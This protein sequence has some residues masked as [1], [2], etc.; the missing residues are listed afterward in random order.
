MEVNFENC[1]LSVSQNCENI[2]TCEDIA[3]SSNLQCEI[4]ENEND[5]FKYSV[6]WKGSDAIDH[7]ANKMQKLEMLQPLVPVGLMAKVKLL[8]STAV[9]PK[10]ANTSDSGWDLVITKIH[11]KIGNVTF[12]STEVS[13]EPPHGYYFDLVPRSSLSKTGYIMANSVGIID[14]SYRGPIIAA[15]MKVD[16]NAEELKLPC[17][18]VQLILRPWYNCLM[19]Q[20]ELTHTQRNDGGFGSTS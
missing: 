4:H 19:K 9:M 11:K 6:V 13:I 5:Q 2:K 20:E 16:P 14:Q 3:H 18:C 15:L 1:T 10:K 8:S 12:F 17:K 7:L